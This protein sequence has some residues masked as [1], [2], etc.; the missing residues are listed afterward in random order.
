[1]LPG[2]WEIREIR[3][4]REI[5]SFCVPQ[6]PKVPKWCHKEESF[7]NLWDL[8]GRLVPSNEGSQAGF[9]VRFPGKLRCDARFPRLRL[10]K[11]K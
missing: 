11:T 7:G 1:M 2:E 6:V 4:I 10:S 3:E 5:W 9:E 8:G